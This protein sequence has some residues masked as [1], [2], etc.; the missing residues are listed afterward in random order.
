MVIEYH[1]F[2]TGIAKVIL[3]PTEKF[4]EGKNYF[5]V[6]ADDIHLVMERESCSLSGDWDKCAY[7]TSQLYRR[8]VRKH[9]GNEPEYVDHINGVGIDNTFRNLNSV[10][11][12]ENS[13]NRVYRG[14]WF[15]KGKFISERIVHRYSSQFGNYRS[16]GSITYSA[17][18][19]AAFH[20]KEFEDDYY[21]SYNYNFF[22]DRRGE[23]DIV[24]LEYSGQISHEEATFMHVMRKAKDNA[25]YVWRYHLFEY[26]KKYD[27]PIPGYKLN[28]KNRMVDVETGAILCP[29]G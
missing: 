6:D 18:D 4:P 1:V 11:A 22:L 23:L 27:V 16:S 24:E 13:K 29:F 20:R 26:F 21:S 14:Y 3:K 17:E 25:W 5:Y 8:I 9:I 10:A 2:D 7:P 28:E 12:C 19:E 15:S